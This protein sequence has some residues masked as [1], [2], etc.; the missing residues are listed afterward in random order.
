MFK[1]E[2]IE[3]IKEAMDHGLV[4]KHV[5]D[6]RVAGTHTFSVLANDNTSVRY[7]FQTFPGQDH[8]EQVVTPSDEKN[9][10]SFSYPSRTEF[11]VYEQPPEGYDVDTNSWPVRFEDQKIA[12]YGRG[13]EELEQKDP[14]V[15]FSLD[16]IHTF[17][18]DA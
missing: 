17:Q 12:L 7:N 4:I 14:F 5:F 18:E 2:Y 1:P 16:V 10:V 13:C 3:S 11:R 8:V 9:L 15:L 6:L